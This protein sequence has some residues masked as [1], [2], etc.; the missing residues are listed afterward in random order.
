[1]INTHIND[2][3]GTRLKEARSV[4]GWSLDKTSQYTGVSKA[5]LGQIERGESSPTVVKLWSIANGFN[6]PLSYFIDALGQESKPSVLSNAE[7]DI[8]VSIL[9][10]YDDVTQLEVF[11]IILFPQREHIS[12][13]HNRGVIEHILA[14]DGSM[15]YYL[16]KMWHTVEQGTA[17]KFCAAQTHGYRNMSDTPVM[18]HNIIRYTC[19]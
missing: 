1:M 12:A 13:P 6:L 15:E 5:M 2:S 14:I 11:Q 3:L 9:C 17:V 10:P 7:Q 8:K 18:I 16:N 4:K 19:D